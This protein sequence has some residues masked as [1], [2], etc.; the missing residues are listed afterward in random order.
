MDAQAKLANVEKIL[1]TTSLSV[2]I[3]EL[4]RSRSGDRLQQMQSDAIIALYDMVKELN[5]LINPMV[6][7][8]PDAAAVRQSARQGQSQSTLSAAEQNAAAIKAAM[9]QSAATT[10]ATMMRS[11][12]GSLRSK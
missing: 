5:A 12:G 9:Q 3:S 11:L 7:L 1:A 2:S 8:L 4:K 6:T 10:N